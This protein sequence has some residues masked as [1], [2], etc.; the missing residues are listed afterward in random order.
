MSD[1]SAKNSE[2]YTQHLVLDGADHPL[3]FLTTLVHG[4]DQLSQRLLTAQDTFTVADRALEFLLEAFGLKQ[5]A[6]LVQ[7]GSYLHPL[8]SRGQLP[9]DILSGLPI[10]TAWLE[11][12]YKHGQPLYLDQD[13]CISEK[14][15]T[16]EGATTFMVYPLGETLPT[17]FILLLASH[18]RRH[19]SK[20]EKEFLVSVCRILSLSLRFAES[21]TRLKTLL[22]LQRH[23][24]TEPEDKLLHEILLAA[25][26]TVPGAEAGSLL[27]RRGK[28]F[29]FR[30]T[31]GYDL[32]ALE[33]FS[34][35]DV[36]ML[37]WQHPELLS[38]E[39]SEPRIF[40]KNDT[41]QKQILG[42]SASPETF[43]SAGRVDDIQSNLYFPIVYQGQVLAVLNLDNF[44]DADAFANDSLE[45]ARMFGPPV[46]VLLRER[47]YRHLLE[48]DSLTD[49]LTN[50]GNRRAFDQAMEREI[51]RAQHYQ[52]PFSLLMLDLGN[53]KA[54]NDTLGHARGDAV[55]IEVAKTL[56][57]VMRS[58]DLL[59]RWGGDEF[60][61]LLLNTAYEGAVVAARRCARAIKR[62]DQ[63]TVSVT[64]HFGV[65]TYPTCANNDTTLLQ[66]AD[67]RLYEAK[68]NDITV[69]LSEE[70]MVKQRKD[71]P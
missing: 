71:H 29:H 62:I 19:W 39:S 65:A 59:F 3:N 24:L 26:Q 45:A 11:P 18:K 4:I 14:Q 58:S 31:V 32:K 60:A 36:D 68:L 2:S 48:K 70:F 51:T 28:K 44:H 67:E 63:Q 13:S 7:Q 10:T 22:T 47:R 49:P 5:G 40:S 37:Y 21:Q 55:L 33:P 69:F 16:L 12:C 57:K 42:N 20:T 52:N 30:A 6:L 38:W 41:G 66:L 34:F 9:K 46:A 64:A 56:R 23:S 25:V 17:R 54:I 53:F 15:K 61:V 50:L 8:A 27:L 1:V 43:R 35:R